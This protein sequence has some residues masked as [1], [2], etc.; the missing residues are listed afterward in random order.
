M[1][2]REKVSSGQEKRMTKGEGRD[3]F[4]GMVFGKRIK[5]V[6]IKDKSYS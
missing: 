2:N 5:I 4:Q 6:F 3:A 1:R